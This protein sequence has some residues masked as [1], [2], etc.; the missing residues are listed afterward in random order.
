[1]LESILAFA[2]R[3]RWLVAL[4][5]LIV[6][7][8]GA[9]LLPR[10]PIDAVPDITNRQVQVNVLAPALGPLE[11]E[12][13][14]SYPIETA[15]TG[16]PG[17][18][19]TRSLSRNG[20]AQVTAVFTDATDLYFARA[21]VSER[22]QRIA[23]QLPPGVQPQIGPVT[24]GLGE[25][26]SF[27]VEFARPHSPVAAG[28]PGW[29]ADGGYLTREGERL[30]GTI[31][32][33]TYLRTVLDWIVRPQMRHVPGIA[34]VDAIGGYV[35][36]YHVA[37]DPVRLAAYGLSLTDLVSALDNANLGFG[38]GVVERAGEGLAVRADARI[39]RGGDIADTVIATRGDTPVRVRDVAD[40]RL[41]HEL[42]TGAAT[43]N[44][45]EVVTGT[46]LMIAGGNSRT[47]ASAAREALVAVNL[48]LPPG[49]VAKPVIDR[50]KL[51]DATIATVTRNLAEGALLVIVVLFLMLG[52]IR[53]A[54]ITAAV[55][56]VSMLIAST[57]MIAGH[58][59]GNLMSLGALD[60]G[61]IVDGAVIIVENCL[62]RIAER[63]REAARLLTQTERLNTVQGAAVEMLRPSL[64]GQA[65]IILVYVPLFAFEGVEAKMFQPMA[66]TVMLAL[67]AAF[68]LSLTLVPAL[69]AL[70]MTGRV[71]EKES[72]IVAGAHRLYVPALDFGLRRPW[73]V[74]GISLAAVVGAGLLFGTLG[75]EFIPQLDEGDIAAE[76]IRIPSVS[77]DQ[78]LV[79]QGQVERA[80]GSLP[81]VMT[82]LGR[83]GTADAGTD[84]MGVNTTDT[85]VVIKPRKDWPNPALTKTQ[86][87]KEIEARLKP[88]LG[89][90]YELSQPIQLRFNELIAGVKADVAVRVYGDDFDQLRPV[91]ADVAR[92]IGRVAGAADVAVEQTQGA[93]A[94]AV[95]FDRAAIA[96]YGLSVR[97]VGDAVEVALGGREAGS[98]YEGD[99]RFD[100]V[101]RLPDAL[102]GDLDALGALPVKLHGADGAAAQTVL[103][104]QVVRFEV[105]DAP[106]QV[107]RDNGK[108]RIV[109]QANVRGTD[110][111]SFIAG[112]QAAVAQGVKLPPGSW[113]EWGGQ[114]KNL[115]R[116]QAR[117]TL[118]VPA[119]FL[120]I[121]ALLFAAL[122]TAG[123]AAMVFSAVPLAL[124]GGVVML[125][126]RGMPFSI[127]AAVGFI[128]LSGVAV[129]NGLV[130]LTSILELRDEGREVD[131]A[132]REGALM[133]LRPVLMTALVA[134]LG[135]V[136]MALATGTGA[137]VQRPLA[138]VV[139]GGLVTAT[140]LTLIVLP[141]L[142]RLVLRREARG[143][144]VHDAAVGAA[145]A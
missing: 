12:K 116:A 4:L 28:Q 142:A 140:L 14:V 128:A 9:A 101:V 110:L 124:T 7:A 96:S 29:Q 92:A 83:T 141:V 53:A 137:E 145:V 127:S 47:V 24:T 3:S 109:V 62:R 135:F 64:Y 65:I 93:P 144:R 42:R 1:M 57:G 82:V 134:S 20:Y 45:E 130:M 21:Q 119:V 61:L 13:Q 69:V 58:V 78:A 36:Q 136:P 44:G 27:T 129:L 85:I 32:Q 95:R 72:W 112:A 17:L 105:V 74:L 103:L 46:T 73:P 23:A 55:I 68:V 81:Q 133:R 91:A 104:R 89:N 49:I 139:I 121:F 22:M 16:I 97:E 50:S 41:G 88:L 8:I 66:I 111:G 25:V 31:E 26:F 76:M 6:A 15:L 79:M 63:Q 143:V 108:R 67:A 38:A 115:Q 56:P 102:R 48:T 59:S 71:T 11:M 10:L 125:A 54:V 94:L 117:L 118:V 113:I 33:A 30:R 123:R 34:E 132:V 126:L 98:V 84:P 90:S 39:A 80:I 106:N 2:V 107:S 75:R 37:P 99:R 122:G 120:L 19:S 87:V 43:E 60:F 77:L 138:T 100:I 18:D 51:V 114:F 52:N 131:D 70:L 5:V 35:K 86:L 40:M